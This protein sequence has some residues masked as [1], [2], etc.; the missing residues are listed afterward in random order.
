GLR[1]F[2]NLAVA[3][4]SLP[5]RPNADADLRR[6]TQL[7]YGH[8]ESR[9]LLAGFLVRQSLRRVRALVADV[10]QPGRAEDA[11][12]LVDQLPEFGSFR[13]GR[14]LQHVGQVDARRQFFSLDVRPPA[15]FFSL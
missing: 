7:A 9:G 11:V 4:R 8:I 5:K 12:L 3:V 1:P 15:A 10:V 13:V 2:W 14:Q 6:R